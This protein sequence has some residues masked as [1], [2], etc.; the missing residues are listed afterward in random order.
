MG[1]IRSSIT[2]VA[3]GEAIANAAEPV[4]TPTPAGVEI[5]TDE[6]AIAQIEQVEVEGRMVT[7]Q[8]IKTDLT[9]DGFEPAIVVVQRRLPML[10]TI[11]VDSLD[12][13]SDS[14]IFPAY[15]S[16]VQTGQVGATIRIIPSFD[17]EFS[18]GDN[19]FYGYVKVVDNISRIDI[20][21]IKAEVAAFE[22]LIYPET[23]FETANSGGCACC[24]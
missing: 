21:A 7:V 17:F 13:G 18:T 22:T 5:P 19:V 2:V 12:P 4:I 14:L 15:Y 8:T 24:R 16:V 3:E 20:D 6:I 9:D 1:M 11:S 10:W 23:H